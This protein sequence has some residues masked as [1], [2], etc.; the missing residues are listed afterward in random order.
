MASAPG[1][2][3]NRYNHF[4]NV[5]WQG[6]WCN[7]KTSGWSSSKNWI[8][9]LL[10]IGERAS[11]ADD[12]RDIKLVAWIGFHTPVVPSKHV[13]QDILQLWEAPTV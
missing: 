10:C 1:E 7:A 9:V 12:R 6:G 8:D 13:I 3:P 5:C 2:L 4:L 11:K